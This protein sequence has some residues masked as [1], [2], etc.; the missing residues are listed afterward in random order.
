[1]LWVG[2]VGVWLNFFTHSRAR[3]MGLA[4]GGRRNLASGG[5]CAH[6]ELLAVLPGSCKGLHTSASIPM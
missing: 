4:A 3:C 6:A 2:V 5:L 1:M